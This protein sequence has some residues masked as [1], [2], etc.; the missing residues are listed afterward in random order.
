MQNNVNTLLSP[1]CIGVIFATL[2]LISNTARNGLSGSAKAHVSAITQV[3]KLR[4]RAHDDKLG[5]STLNYM[6]KLR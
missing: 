4:S 6:E 1:F 5:L 3:K 2:S